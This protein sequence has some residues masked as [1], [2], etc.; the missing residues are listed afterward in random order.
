[1]FGAASGLGSDFNLSALDGTNG[2][3]IAGVAAGDQAG[4]SVCGAGD[5][6]GDGYD[7][8]LVGASRADAGGADSGAAYLIYGAASGLGSNV[9]L[10]ALDGVNGFRITGASAGDLAGND[11]SA[12]GDVNGDGFADLIVGAPLASAGGA[13][14]GA[15]YVIYGGDFNGEAQLVG[16][17]GSDTLTGGGTD[18]FHAGAGND[19]IQLADGA[20]FF[21]ADGGAGTDTLALLGSSDLLDFTALDANAARGIEKIDLGNAGN[22]LKIEAVDLLNLSDTSN[23]LVVDGGGTSIVDISSEGGWT[24]DGTSG[25]YYHYSNGEAKLDVATAISVLGAT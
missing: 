19:R 1:V 16:S 17:A 14:S 5:V 20:T 2:F 25:G 3:S 21:R 10:S 9:E 11:V 8:V 4:L 7:D 18:A 24:L 22:T 23:L 15:G 6:N 13:Q 12:A